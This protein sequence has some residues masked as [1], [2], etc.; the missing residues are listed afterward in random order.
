MPSSLKDVEQVAI[1]EDWLH[2][3]LSGLPPLKQTEM[4]K[5]FEERFGRSIDVKTLKR[6]L[7]EAFSDGLVRLER[8]HLDT[9]S[10]RNETLERELSDRWNLKGAIVVEIEQGYDDSD[11]IHRHLGIHLAKAIRS[12]PG[13]FRDDDVIAIGSGRATYHFVVALSRGRKKIDADSI[14]IMS[15]TGTVYPEAPIVRP[16]VT[17]DADLAAAHM[18]ACFSGPVTLRTIG[19]PIAHY[20]V[21]SVRKNTWLFDINHSDGD[22]SPDDFDDSRTK[23]NL[24][25]EHKPNHAFIGVGVLSG[26][27]RLYREVTVGEKT[28]MLDPI[29]EDL[30][31]VIEKSKEIQHDHE[32]YYPVADICNRLFLVDPPPSLSVNDKKIL[33]EIRQLINKVNKNML[34]VTKMQL[35]KARYV[36]MIAGGER[37]VPALRTLLRRGLIASGTLCTDA[38]TAEVLIAE[39]Q[40]SA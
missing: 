14:R 4:Q 8:G 15:L 37:K 9:N 20:D 23:D 11:S 34:T 19:H 2:P 7:I 31:N 38:K 13:Y 12:I 10:H 3:L 30:R 21:P 35:K 25:D 39:K 22:F 26:R 40:V 5:K 16:S 29:R 32:D 24:F 33:D 27:H 18:A 6:G 17:L 1:V 28:P 36:N